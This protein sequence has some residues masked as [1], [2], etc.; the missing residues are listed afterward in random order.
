MMWISSIIIPRLLKSLLDFNSVSLALSEAKN[1]HETIRTSSCCDS[2]IIAQAGLDF[3]IEVAYL[4][5]LTYSTAG[6]Y[7][8]SPSLPTGIQINQRNGTISGRPESA[9][10]PK[11]YTITVET[12]NE[13]LDCIISIQVN[14]KAPSN[15]QYGATSSTNIILR[16]GISV[17]LLPSVENGSDNPQFSFSGELPEGLFFSATDGLISGVPLAFRKAKSLTVTIKTISGSCSCTFTITV[18]PNWGH[19]PMYTWTSS[20]VRMWLQHE[21]GVESKAIQELSKVTGEDLIKLKEIGLPWF[22]AFSIPQEPL[23]RY[24]LQSVKTAI[25]EEF[26]SKRLLLGTFARGDP[27]FEEHLPIEL[28]ARLNAVCVLG[29]GASGAVLHVKLHGEIFRASAERAIKLFY[30]PGKVGTIFNVHD[31]ARMSREASLMAK[32][33]SPHVV[34]YIESGLSRNMDVAWILMDYMEGPTLQDLINT[35]GKLKEAECM[36]V[37]QH[38][39][40]GL[41]AIHDIGVI[42]RDIK[43]DNIILKK[44]GPSHDK[45]VI[46]DLGISVGFFD[47][48][49]SESML[50]L[51]SGIIKFAGTLP[52]MAPEMFRD[53]HAVTFSS[54]I[55]ALGVTLFFSISGKFPFFAPNDMMWSTVIAGD[56]EARPPDPRQHLPAGELSDPFADV[57]QKSL[58]KYIERRFRGADDMLSALSGPWFWSRKRKVLFLIE[59]R[60]QIARGITAVDKMYSD[61]EAKCKTRLCGENWPSKLVRNIDWS[62]SGQ[63]GPWDELKKSEEKNLQ[64]PITGNFG[65]LNFVRNVGHGHTP[66]IVVRKGLFSNHDEVYTYLMDPFPWLAPIVYEAL[67]QNNLEK[68]FKDAGD[69]PFLSYGKQR[70]FL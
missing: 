41:K 43:T 12:L 9:S 48:G 39:L 7:S 29:T 58:E 64:H 20:M 56:M 55:W 21:L 31:Q 67:I 5:H 10:A 4:H 52:Y 44:E 2:K 65:L 63:R 68:I 22:E 14:P 11:L 40:L 36:R 49:C 16:V 32:I 62:G 45:Y 18:L 3:E 34:K 25:A 35:N 46:I 6:L 30:A 27:A 33:N 24:I 8:V 69:P 51:T 15:L 19:T 70:L 47:S 13:S 50:S 1:M 66:E 26:V 57:I 17:D 38:V 28:R 37:A 23:R 60:G 61:I 53:R 59:V 42:H 54:D